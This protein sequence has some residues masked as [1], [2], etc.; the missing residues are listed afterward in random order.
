MSKTSVGVT[1]HAAKDTEAN[2]VDSIEG[3]DV[4][5]ERITGEEISTACPTKYNLATKGRDAGQ[6]QET[7]SVL[8]PDDEHADDDGDEEG[9]FSDLLPLG[10]SD[11]DIRD[12]WRDSGRR[13]DIDD[14]SE[15][16]ELQEMVSSQIADDVAKAVALTLFKVANPRTLH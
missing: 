10:T 16:D 8:P 9:K 14:M 5:R 1:V 7:I 6:M 2:V 11:L 4:I 13:K 3:V 12:D 15:E